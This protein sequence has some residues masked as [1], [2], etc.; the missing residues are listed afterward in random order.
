MKMKEKKLKLIITFESMSDAINLEKILKKKNIEGRLIPVPR[1][2]SSGC[3]TVWCSDIELK[4]QITEIISHEK[5][6]INKIYEIY[7]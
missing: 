5:T 3:G 1:E 4:E 6:D 2:I 7:K